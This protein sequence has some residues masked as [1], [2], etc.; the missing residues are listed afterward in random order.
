MERTGIE[1]RSDRYASEFLDPRVGFERRTSEIEVRTDPLTGRTAR[2]G[3]PRGSLDLAPAAPEATES[4]ADACLFCAPL[5]FE[6]TPR[7][8]LLA[9]GRHAVGEAFLFPN[10]FPSTLESAVCV[11]T[12]SHDLDLLA[13]DERRIADALRACRDFLHLAVRAHPPGL[14]T[15]ILARHRSADPGIAHPHL[16]A[17]ADPSPLDS[18]RTTADGVAAYAARTGRRFHEDLVSAEFEAERGLARLRTFDWIVPFCPLGPLHVEAVGREPRALEELAD[19]DLE[20]LADGLVRVFRGCRRAGVGTL[21]LRFQAGASHDTD[22]RRF[23][24]VLEV[25]ARSEGRGGLPDGRPPMD[26]RGPA[27]TLATR[28]ERVAELL[29]PPFAD[30]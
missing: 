27:R 11:F 6:K 3:P 22:D 2:F 8:P 29:R 15:T 13:Y 30:I 16:R 24:P 10:L 4:A 20:D 12:T 5:V 18:T 26:A 19:H 7:S 21:D 25:I 23:P 9:K 14:H 1:F 17:L 28:P